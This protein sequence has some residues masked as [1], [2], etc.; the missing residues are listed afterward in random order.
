MSDDDIRA[1]PPVTAPAV[2]T[3]PAA[4][5]RRRRVWPWLLAG[6]LLLCLL[7]IGGVGSALW[8]LADHAQQ[9]W[10]V[11]INGQP[12]DGFD[13]FNG[14]G[15]FEGW[16]GIHWHQG[17]HSLGTLLGLGVAGLVLTVV[18]AVV[19]PVS[20]LFAVL[21]PL[22]LGG[23]GVGLAL[24]AVLGSVGLVVLLLGSPIW[25]LVLLCWLVLRKRPRSLPASSGAGA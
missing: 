12:W 1:F 15:A 6:S 2:P 24:V 9:D 8:A 22:L 19:L 3:A 13:G 20:L 23:L 5:A 14:F 16:D 4:A 7:L 10:P 18:L 17:H 25:L 11:V 21:L